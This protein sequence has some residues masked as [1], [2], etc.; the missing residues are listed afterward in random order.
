MADNET[1]EKSVVAQIFRNLNLPQ[2]LA[3]RLGKAL[4]GLFGNA[5]DIPTAYIKRVSQGIDDKTKAKSLVSHEIAKA[6]ADKASRDPELVERALASMLPGYLKR[7]ENKEAIARKAIELL[8]VPE[9]LAPEEPPPP[10][11]EPVQVDDDWLNVFERYAEDAS[12]ERLRDTWARV[13]AGEIRKPKSFSLITL[14]FIS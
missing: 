10:G 5:L 7:H 9:P 4:S 1:P 6:V 14:R 11:E 8:A 2:L 13:L 3:G 12:S